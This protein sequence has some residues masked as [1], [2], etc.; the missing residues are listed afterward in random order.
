M[1]GGDVSSHRMRGASPVMLEIGTPLRG[2][3]LRGVN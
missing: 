2:K 1:R 3:R